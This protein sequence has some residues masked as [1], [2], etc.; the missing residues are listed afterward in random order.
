MKFRRKKL[1]FGQKIPPK[2]I[3]IWPKNLNLAYK[4][5]FGQKMEIWP[6]NLNLAYKMKFGQKMEIWPK[7]GNLAKKWKFDRKMKK[8]E[9]LTKISGTIEIC[10]KKC[11]WP[12][13]PN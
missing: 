11:N 3:E 10:P 1:K 8:L 9:I 13:N 7:N 5:K 12:K 4:M 2:K 6:K